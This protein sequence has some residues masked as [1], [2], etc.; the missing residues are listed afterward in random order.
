MINK[1]LKDK[2]SDINADK[3]VF[4]ISVVAD[5]LQVHQRTLRIYNEENILVPARSP[6]NRR[7]YSINDIERGKFVQHLSRELGIN[8]I[9]I[10]IILELLKDRKVSFKDY[11]KHLN[12]IAERLNITEEIQMQNREKLSKRGRKPS[13]VS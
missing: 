9:G 5:I 10:K 7:L 4:P 3:P 2:Q 13:K 1:L 8:I 12:I 6:K 11:R